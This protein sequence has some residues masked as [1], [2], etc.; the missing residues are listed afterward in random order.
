MSFQGTNGENVP[1][2]YL[3]S[4][5]KSDVNSTPSQVPCVKNDLF[6]GVYFLVLRRKLPVC[7]SVKG[8]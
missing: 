8:P 5:T 2:L 4:L 6:F 7:C 3:D 1:V